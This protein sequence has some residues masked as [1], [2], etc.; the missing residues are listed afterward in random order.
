[1]TCND[2]W[3]DP[4]WKRAHRAVE[5]LDAVELEAALSA[6]PDLDINGDAYKGYTL[7][8]YALDAEVSIHQE[9]G[10]QGPTPAPVSLVLLQHGA[11]PHQP[12]PE[13]W[14]AIDY[15]TRRNHI[16]FLNGLGPESR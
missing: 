3:D 12:H 16:A 1:M 5:E 9:S 4:A 15:A 8:L 11:D 7:L 6:A 10:V 2:L 14:T 13:G